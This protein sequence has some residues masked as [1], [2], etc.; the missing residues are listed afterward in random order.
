MSY[1]AA[2]RLTWVALFGVTFGLS[3]VLSAPIVAVLGAVAAAVASIALHPRQRWWNEFP[4]SRET[5][6]AERPPITTWRHLAVYLWAF[7]LFA[8]AVVCG[9]FVASLSH[10]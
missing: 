6:P 10:L 3:L 2:Y 8:F 4:E 9:W 5:T 1:L 7:A